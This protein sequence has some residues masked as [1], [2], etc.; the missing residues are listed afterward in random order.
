MS[1]SQHNFEELAQT[2]APL[3]L[4]MHPAGRAILMA[5]LVLELR[6]SQAKRIAQQKNTDGSSFAPRK[7][8]E[9]KS[10][11]EKMFNKIRTTQ[12]LRTFS[13]SEQAAV[14]FMGRIARIARVHQYG[15]MDS[16]EQGQRKVKY[17]KRDLLGFSRSDIEMIEKFIFA[18]IAE[19]KN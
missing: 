8:R 14:G 12:H 9:Q 4:Q 16:P 5:K 19:N 6:R 17:A 3:L 13:N 18:Y 15:L 7:L 11:R 1:M 2:I 10:I